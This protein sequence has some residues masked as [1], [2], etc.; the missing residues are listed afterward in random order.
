MEEA[1]KIAMREYILRNL[2]LLIEGGF[3]LVFVVLTAVV[4]NPD[5]Q[6]L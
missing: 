4:L 1:Y 5:L 6:D 3:G 2:Q